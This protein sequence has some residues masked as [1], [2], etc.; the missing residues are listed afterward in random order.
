ME[1][2]GV[3][4]QLLEE[5]EGRVLWFPVDGGEPYAAMESHNPEDVAL[6]IEERAF[7]LNVADDDLPCDENG[8]PIFWR[9]VQVRK[10]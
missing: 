4:A 5:G 6:V 9:F 8:D 1:L 7:D 10:I 2:L 3:A